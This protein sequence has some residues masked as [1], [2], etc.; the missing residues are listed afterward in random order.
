MK[1]A[2]ILTGFLRTY[3]DSFPLLR[4]T[5]L[6]RYDADI[7]L[8]TW[9]R[10]ENGLPTYRNFDS[11][12]K[13][14]Q[15]KNTI[16]E[17]L[18]VYNKNKHVIHKIIRPDDVFETNHRAKEHGEYWANRLK[19]QWYLVQKCFS[20]IEEKHN[21]D[22]I[23]RLRYDLFLYDIVLNKRGGITAPQDIGGWRFTDHMAYGDPQSMEKYCFL[24]DNIYKLY[25]LYNLDI[26]HA[27]EM[28]KFYLESYGVPV[29]IKTDSSIRYLIRK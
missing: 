4:N 13:N 6:D 2:I 15:V 9:D 10:Q 25:E 1:V 19:D 12:Y 7:Y 21:Y 23:L 14:Y 3:T 28:P 5:I 11:I 29:D 24:H 8:A 27:V 17:N 22:I 20:S 18:S 16:I 26:T